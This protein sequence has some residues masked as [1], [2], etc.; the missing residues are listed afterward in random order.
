M[1]VGL[2]EREMAR[3]SARDIGEEGGSGERRTEWSIQVIHRV[4]VC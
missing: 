1:E 4:D 2:R 3:V